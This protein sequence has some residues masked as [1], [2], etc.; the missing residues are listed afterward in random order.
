M[1]ALGQKRT[2]SDISA[3]PLTVSSRVRNVILLLY[4]QVP[5]SAC[6]LAGKIADPRAAKHGGANARGRGTTCFT[7]AGRVFF[8][9]CLL[10]N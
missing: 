7:I 3:F 10:K 8:I 5:L 4:P 9:L 1:S 2:L 6:R